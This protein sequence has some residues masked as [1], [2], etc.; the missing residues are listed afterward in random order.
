MLC[1]LCILVITLINLRGVKES[2]KIFAIPTYLFI[3]SFFALIAI[4]LVGYVARRTAPLS[5]IT[6]PSGPADRTI[7]V[8]SDLASICLRL[9][10]SHR[11]GSHLER[12]TGLST[13]RG[14]ECQHHTDVD[15]GDFGK[16]L[17]RYYLFGQPLRRDAQ[18][19]RD[20]GI[21]TGT[22]NLW[23]GGILLPRPS[24]HRAH[25]NPGSQYELCRL[26]RLASLLGRDHFLPR[27][28]AN[29]GDRLV[30]SN[31]IIILGMLAALLIV[32]FQAH[33]HA[34]IPLYA[35][36]V[37][38]SFTLSQTGMVKRWLTGRPTGWGKGIAIN[39]VG[40]LTTAVV[41]A[42]IATTKF[43]HGAW[44]VLLLLPTLA[45]TLRKI[46]HHYRLVAAQISLQEVKL[47]QGPSQH[48]VLLPVS[49]LS[50]QM[51][52]AL[53]YAKLLSPDVR[54]VYIELD[55]ETT[56]DLRVEWKKWGYGVALVV[57]HSPYRS[58]VQ[59]LLHY[60]EDVQDESPD[61]IVTVILPEFVPAKWWQHVLHNQTALQIKGALLFKKGVIVT[62]VPYHL[63]R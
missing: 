55:P 47:P 42:I 62:S 48:T 17:C 58:I 3:A 16:L 45:F 26:S 19:G 60:I 27:Q 12:R 36:G 52:T 38:L 54:A 11:R 46:H 22:R 50:R 41:L 25:P 28:M 57:L 6:Q 14:E 32:I 21:A 40:A 63:T 31:G 10:G 15:G 4:G 53:H 20:R 1:L 37:F 34:L 9:Y 18:R 7:D 2:G 35:V 8:V 59:P 43:T 49:G 56:A 33:T 13:S 44:V 5:S 24:I 30:F 29:R 51:I 61:Q 39:S 23:W